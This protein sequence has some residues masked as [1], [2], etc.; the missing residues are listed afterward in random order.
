MRKS[1]AVLALILTVALAVEHCRQRGDAQ[2]NMPGV[3]PR[4]I[5][6]VPIDMKNMVGGVN[7]QQM[8]RNHS[9]PSPLNFFNFF[10]KFSQPTFPPRIASAPILSPSQSPLAP[11][12]GKQIPIGLPINQ[13]SQ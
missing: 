10:H 9:A 1:V 6:F 7:A 5:T 4:N 11:P 12:G 13:K 3:S 8:F 2:V